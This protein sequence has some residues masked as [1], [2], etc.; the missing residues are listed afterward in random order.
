[1]DV[2][3]KDGG[4]AMEARG[5]RVLYGEREALT[6]VSLC[7]PAGGMTGIIGPN[8]AGKT[9]LLRVLCGSIR[10]SEGRVMICGRPLDDISRREVSQMLAVV[11]QGVDIPVAYTVGELVALGRTPYLSGWQRLSPEDVSAVHRALEMADLIGFEDRLVDEL[12]AGE[13]QRALVALALAQEPSMLLLDEPTAH[14][15]IQHAWH[16][17]EIISDLN[18]N[19]GVTVVM[20]LHDLNLAAEFCSDLVL[21]DHGRVVR[22]GA[23]AEVME[24]A[25]LS[26]V[27]AHPVDVVSLDAGRRMVMPRRQIHQ[28][29]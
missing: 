13:R 3:P 10:P 19:H 17:A 18:R 29:E 7:L 1:M 25:E 16:L 27:Y 24:A 4:A 6:G 9:T 26:R 20:S 12:S 21:L 5:V 14:L 2:M 23:A 28:G 11:P 8:G 22:R 15:D